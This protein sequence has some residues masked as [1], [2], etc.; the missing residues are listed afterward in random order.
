MKSIV[1]F[2][3]IPNDV[4]DSSGDEGGESSAGEEEQVEVEA[5][6]DERP[7]GRSVRR[8]SRNENLRREN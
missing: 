6:E 7:R 1:A 5:S 3:A 2:N 4:Y 8:V